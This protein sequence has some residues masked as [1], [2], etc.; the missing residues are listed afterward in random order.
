M[1]R[2]WFRKRGF[3]I[4]IPALLLVLLSCSGCAT[5]TGQNGVETESAKVWVGKKAKGFT[6]PGIDG[7]PVDLGKDLGKRPVVLVFYRGVW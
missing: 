2:S 1:K 7:K 6:L 5:W 3:R 4:L